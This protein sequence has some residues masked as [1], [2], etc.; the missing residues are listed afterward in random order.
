MPCHALPHGTCLDTV[1]STLSACAAFCS[2][3]CHFYVCSFLLFSGLSLFLLCVLLSLT[4][5]HTFALSVTVLSSLEAALSELKSNTVEQRKDLSSSTLAKDELDFQLKRVTQERESALLV[6]SRTQK[7]LSLT[8]DKMLAL[9]A[10][11]M[12]QSGEQEALERQVV[13]LTARLAEAEAQGVTKGEEGQALVQ[14]CQQLTQSCRSQE[15]E[16]A[17]LTEQKR[18]LGGRREEAEQMGAEME[19]LQHDHAALL[20]SSEAQSRQVIE[21]T[22]VLTERGVLSERLVEQSSSCTSFQSRLESSLYETRRLEEL[23]A[24]RAQ[25]GGSLEEEE[26]E[27]GGSLSAKLTAATAQNTDLQGEV[28]LVTRRL[29]DAESLLHQTETS[30]VDLQHDLTRVTASLSQAEQALEAT[31]GKYEAIRQLLRQREDEVGDLTSRGERQHRQELDGRRDFRTVVEEREA[32]LQK[33]RD[34]KLLLK[35]MEGDEREMTGR[36]KRLEGRVA[37]LQGELDGMAAERDDAKRQTRQQTNIV[38]DLQEA[39]RSLDADRDELQHQLD[40]LSDDEARRQQLMAEGHQKAVDL[41]NLLLQRDKLI[42]SL[43]R[44]KEHTREQVAHMDER[45]RAM[46][47]ESAELRRRLG[48]QQQEAGAACADLELM[49]RENQSVTTELAAV[50]HTRE[51]LQQ[52]VAN[53]SEQVSALEH[54]VRALEVERG[55]LL[56]TYRTCLQER[57]KFEVDLSV[58]SESKTRLA[59]TIHELRGEKERRREGE[60]EREMLY[61][62]THTSMLRCHP[63]CPS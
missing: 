13:L 14:K 10:T 59:G 44:D 49:T 45:F 51:R 63:S 48:V 3:H 22:E 43:R 35:N 19:A 34:L 23:I 61:R 62:H 60:K 1:P 5:T 18:I 8:Q 31:R 27:G 6:V 57:R 32:A 25:L 56:E 46:T 24:Q 33:V 52:R 55:D 29:F 30:T 20:G 53:Y 58:M 26:K 17:Q 12:Q 50:S 47:E 54:S 39:L 2:C 28:R 42:E 11:L 7:E 21:L 41:S 40:D 15:V 9:D 38:A 16:I 4:H 36:V 37:V